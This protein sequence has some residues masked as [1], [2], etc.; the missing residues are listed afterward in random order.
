MRN[1]QGGWCVGAA[2]CEIRFAGDGFGMLGYGQPANIIKGR[3][4]PLYSRA[5][6][7]QA[8]DGTVAFFAQSEICMILPEL[9][10]A[11]LARLGQRHGE[12]LFRDDNVML[13]AQHTH[14][15][16]GGYAH[17]PF[18]NFSIPGFRPQVFEA[19]VE[20]L[21]DALRRAF[22][23]RQ[24]ALLHFT[25]GD[26]G[27]D[28]DVAFN[29][30]L[31]AYNRNP[32]VSRCT[33]A[34]THRAIERTM[35][36]LRAE[37]LSGRAIGQINWFGVHPTSIGN[38]NRLVS[39]DNKGYAA[40]AV[41]RAL[42]AEAVAIFAQQFAGDVSPNAQGSG[43]RG[44][45]RGRYRDEHESA[46]FNGHLQSEQALRLLRGLDE[47]HR[48]AD[49]TLDTAVVHRD[50]SNVECD[51]DLVG[52][53][54][55]ERT[56]APCHGLAFFGGSP[57]DGP[58]APRPVLWLLGG[59]ARLVNWRQ[60]WRARRAG[61][62]ALAAWEAQD[63]AQRPKRVVAESAAGRLLGREHLQGLPGGVDP[64]LREIQRQ[65][66][67]G[68]LTEKPWV[69][70]V[71]PLQYLRIGELAL[72]GFPGEITTESGRQM[73]AL[74]AELLA[75]AGVRQVVLSSYA[76]AYFGYC[77]THAEY[78]EQLY[79]GGH[80]TFGNR[81]HDAFRTEYRRLLRECLKPVA[82]RELRSAA[83]QCFSP[84]LL[85]RRS[86]VS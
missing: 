44:W 67:A 5:F 74:C 54:Q 77:T 10:R 12:D 47:R 76:N 80:T 52:G 73:R 69:P 86:V 29:R 13:T 62:E 8:E 32:G 59:L 21:A 36:L 63:K 46:R 22:E 39:H 51:P 50:F 7:F 2:R 81:T 65:A 83:P 34:E 11:L 26:F 9:K 28:V 35:W 85:A 23:R 64:I 20:S 3:A 15:A 6:C 57:I 49:V 30:S 14:S 66:R 70:E 37:T 53:L 48:L 25:H 55:G 60:R 79:E 24:P 27:D 56:S 18:Y 38:R 82:Q 4:T 40:E 75:P 33:R 78:Q 43:K 31:A 19:I 17:F 42:G 68:A 72:I 84:E 1:P 45:P 58:G 41:E 71:L 16:P 61:G